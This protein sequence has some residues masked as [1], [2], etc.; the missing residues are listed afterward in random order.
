[1]ICDAVQNNQLK[2]N[3]GNPGAIPYCIATLFGFFIGVIMGKT[4]WDCG[5]EKELSE[6]YKSK[7]RNNNVSASCK[8]CDRKR[9]DIA[10]LNRRAS[11]RAED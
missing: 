9:L 1:M 6:F 2:P 4:C 3:R 5:L 8:V 7:K 10:C 11:K